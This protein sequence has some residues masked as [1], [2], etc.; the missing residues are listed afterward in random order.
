[1]TVLVHNKLGIYSV[2]VHSFFS[3]NSLLLFSLFQVCT[4]H[5][6]INKKTDHRIFQPKVNSSSSTLSTSSSFFHFLSLFQSRPILSSLTSFLFHLNS[7]LH[8]LGLFSNSYLSQHLILH[9]RMQYISLSPPSFS[10]NLF[11]NLY[12]SHLL[13]ILAFILPPSPHNFIP[14]PQSTTCRLYVTLDIRTLKHMLYRLFV[15]CG[16]Y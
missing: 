7:G 2:S 10:L 9:V 4:N 5:S 8:I 16:S 12:L 11:S 3:L 15:W 6:S 13:P 1:M 14:G